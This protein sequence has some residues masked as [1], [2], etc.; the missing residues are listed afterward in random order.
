MNRTK[1]P[2]AGADLFRWFKYCYKIKIKNNY[3]IEITQ[4]ALIFHVN[5]PQLNLYVEKSNIVSLNNGNASG[6]MKKMSKVDPVDSI[7]IYKIIRFY[8]ILYTFPPLK[9]SRYHLYS[10]ETIF[11]LQI[12]LSKSKYLFYFYIFLLLSVVIIQI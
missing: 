1:K 12:S 3:H 5:C 7:F 10:T 11:I 8:I 6:T 2:P 9:I 4:L